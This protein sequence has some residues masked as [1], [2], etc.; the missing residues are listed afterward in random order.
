VTKKTTSETPSG[1]SKRRITLERTYSAP[2]EQVWDLWTTQART[3]S[4][5]A[6]AE[7]PLEH[8]APPQQATA[9]P[10]IGNGQLIDDEIPF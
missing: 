5:R 9:P 4:R 3:Q 6:R 2:I 1:P 10:S 7:A 8:R